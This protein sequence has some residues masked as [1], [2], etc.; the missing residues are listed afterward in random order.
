LL[1]WWKVEDDGGGAYA[2]MSTG[3]A[4]TDEV[5]QCMVLLISSIE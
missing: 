4:F 5:F 3:R 1:G 2:I